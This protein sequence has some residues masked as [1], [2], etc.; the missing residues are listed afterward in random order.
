MTRILGATTTLLL[1]AGFGVAATAAAAAASAAA[2]TPEVGWWWEGRVS[3]S[4]PVQPDPVPAVPK[5]G[6]YV[7]A[8]PSGPSAE[9][10][11][12]V[13]LEPD[14][15]EPIL[16]LEISDTIGTPSIDAC[17]A[18]SGWSPVDG[19]VWAERP[20]TDCA[21]KV[22]GAVSADGTKVSFALASL[23]GEGPIDVVLVPAAS[24][25][26]SPAVFSTTFRPPGAEAVSA[27]SVGSRDDP[28]PAALPDAS[29]VFVGITPDYAT[30]TVGY[31][32]SAMVLPEAL[33]VAEVVAPPAAAAAG[34]TDAQR[35][36]LADV[37]LVAPEGFRY[38]VV[39]ALPLVLLAACG[40]VGWSL[41]RPIDLEGG[42]VRRGR[43]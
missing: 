28:A 37:A 11:V 10:A 14:S 41:T 9:S 8:D 3:G 43:A 27:A 6:L 38:A 18:A 26:G 23:A 20:A 24:A 35:A 22:T 16:T 31:T 4:V 36:T 17:A 29:D 33:P 25:T 7:A 32:A 39:L 12:R 5:G 30:S 21:H 15:T 19:G 42:E 1:A 40:Y 13:A 2:T 34:P